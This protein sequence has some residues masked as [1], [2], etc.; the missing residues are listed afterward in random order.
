MLALL[1]VLLAAPSGSLPYVLLPLAF[2][3]EIWICLG[4]GRVDLAPNLVFCILYSHL[5][6]L[7]LQCCFVSGHLVANVVDGDAGQERR[8]IIA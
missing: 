8:I 3:S 7:R 4:D 1:D 6:E 2:F 5:T